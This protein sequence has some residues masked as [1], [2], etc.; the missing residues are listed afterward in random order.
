MTSAGL[1]AGASFHFLTGL[2]ICTFFCA[3]AIRP[4]AERLANA[5]TWVI[6]SIAASLSSALWIALAQEGV[7]IVTVVPL[8]FAAFG[9]FVVPLM[10]GAP[11]MCFPRVN[12]GSYVCYFLGGVVILFSFLVPGGPAQGGWPSYSPIALSFAG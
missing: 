12:M 11:D 6:A 4:F 10:I 9:N 1:D 3:L 7:L 8:A 2:V 5:R